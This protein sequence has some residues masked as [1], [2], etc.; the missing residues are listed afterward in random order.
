MCAG[1]H[2]QTLSYC[3]TDCAISI[4]EHIQVLNKL[5]AGPDAAV[6]M[7]TVEALAPRLW[8]VSKILGGNPFL[9]RNHPMLVEWA[10]II[11][12]TNWTKT[13]TKH[14]KTC[15]WK[16]VMSMLIYLDIVQ[17]RWVAGKGNKDGFPCVCQFHPEEDITVADFASFFHFLW[18]LV[19]LPSPQS[20]PEPQQ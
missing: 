20:C 11:G 13:I 3:G 1:F 16:E 17:M 15:W 18:V 10:N 5:V 2:P 14:G 12:S 9:C 4:S 8:M 19:L 7:A 6:G